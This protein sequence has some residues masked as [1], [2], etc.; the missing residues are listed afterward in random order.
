MLSSGL[1]TSLAATSGATWAKNSSNTSSGPF[2]SSFSSSS[3]SCSSPLASSPLFYSFFYLKINASVY[4]YNYQI[5][6][7]L[8]S[9]SFGAYIS[10]TYMVPEIG[11]I[12]WSNGILFMLVQ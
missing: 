2:S 10:L 1:R 7:T 8:F 6:F 5:Y 12:F 4:H 9:F 3:S 11:S